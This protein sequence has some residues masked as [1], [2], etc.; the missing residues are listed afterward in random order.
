MSIEYKNKLN[1][2]LQ[3]SNSG[4]LYFSSW[5]KEEGYSDQLIKKYRD[6]GWFDSL[7]KGV[8]FRKGEK[9][10]SFAVLN[11]YNMQMKKN[12]IVAAHSALE[13]AGFNHFVPMGKPLLM[14]T[15][16]KAEKLP[17]W[18]KQ[19]TFDRTIKTFTT[20]TFSKKFTSPYN[21]E[22]QNLRVSVPEQAFLECL[23]LAPYQ[24][25]YVDLFYILEQL[26]SLRPDI[27]N[28]L[29]EN[30]GNIKVKRTFLYM[31]EKAN[32]AWLNELTSDN[33]SLGTSKLQ[34]AQQGVYVPKFKITI[35]KELFEYE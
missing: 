14:V 3:K 21:E 6:S 15:H 30:T 26:T 31:A 24:Y 2:L 32:H 20:E 17:N 1:Q 11:S 22:F 8:I 5:L 9:L 10:N 16:S 33:L 34:L 29:L 19:E 35:P 23:L 27:L 13:L 25:S 4:G 12:F 7:S 18:L 28:Q